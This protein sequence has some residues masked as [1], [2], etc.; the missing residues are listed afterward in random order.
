MRFRNAGS[1]AD[2]RH[3]TSEAGDPTAKGWHRVAVA[4]HRQIVPDDLGCGRHGEKLAR[5]TPRRV[6]RDVGRLDP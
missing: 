3:T 5:G 2:G 6:V 1:R 4:G